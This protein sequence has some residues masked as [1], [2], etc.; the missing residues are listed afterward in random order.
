MPCFHLRHCFLPAQTQTG[1]KAW[2][3]RRETLPP[4]IACSPA[5][6]LCFSKRPTGLCMWNSPWLTKPPKE[7]SRQTKRCQR[8]VLWRIHKTPTSWVV[9]LC[10]GFCWSFSGCSCPRFSNM[11]VDLHWIFR[12]GRQVDFVLLFIRF[13]F[14]FPS[15]WGNDPIWQAFLRLN[16]HQQSEIWDFTVYPPLVPMVDK[17][18]RLHLHHHDMWYGR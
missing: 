16:S 5:H 14:G 4:C 18:V 3:Y 7:W 9:K 15:D 13:S 6:I 10:N 17:L 2:R 8:K 11:Q 1:R 12:C